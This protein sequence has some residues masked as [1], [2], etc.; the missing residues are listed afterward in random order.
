MKN[1]ALFLACLASGTMLASCTQ[2]Q[3]DRPEA[4]PIT[5][6]PSALPP[7]KAP[8]EGSTFPEGRSFVVS[9][10]YYATDGG[11]SGNY[12]SGLTFSKNGSTWSADKY[13][14][15]GGAL[16]FLA[17]SSP[18][19]GVSASYNGATVS[20]QV[21]LIVPD[22]S[23]VQEDILYGYT[24]Q[25][26]MTNSVAIN[27]LHA[28][29]LICFKAKSSIAYNATT[30]TGITVTGITLN[31]ASYSGTC[32]I[33]HGSCSWEALGPGKNLEV[34]GLNSTNLGTS[35]SDVLGTGILVPVQSCTSATITYT[36]HNGKQ[37]NGSDQNMTGL[38]KTVTLTADGSMWQAGNRYTY[39]IDITQ[40]GVSISPVVSPWIEATTATVNIP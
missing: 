17:F 16:D 8:V 22:N 31:S 28:Q 29:A 30:N 2:Q 24:A 20:T 18:D 40:H 3:P 25:T 38:V 33:G 6:S 39:Q 21:A 9:S 13:W 35:Y 37:A 36:L 34:P 26:P 1:L 27:F 32:T 10:Y 11:T 19:L 5:F 14:P 7:T 4:S 12:F 15:L 23:T